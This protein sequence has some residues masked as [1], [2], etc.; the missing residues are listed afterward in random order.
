MPKTERLILSQLSSRTR[1][2]PLSSSA[3]AGGVERFRTLGMVMVPRKR[4]R[5]RL[6]M[7]LGLRQLESTHLNRSL[8]W[9]LKLFRSAQNPVNNRRSNSHVA[10]PQLKNSPTRPN[11]FPSST[12]GGHSRS[13]RFRRYGRGEFVIFI[14]FCNEGRANIRFFTIGTC[15]LAETIC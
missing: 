3:N 2:E 7:P 8:W 5:T 9:R 12:L 6:S 14:F 15:F 4:L 11:Q 13:R 10:F 1:N